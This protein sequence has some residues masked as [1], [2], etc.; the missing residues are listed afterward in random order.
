MAIF[1]AMFEFSDDASLVGTTADVWVTAGRTINWADTDLEMGGTPLWFNARVGTT[2]YAGGTSIQIKLWS[3][4]AAGGHDASS[5]VV[6]EGPIILTAAATAGAWL[7][8][9]P[10]PYNVDDLQ[11]LGVGA[12]LDGAMTAGTVDAW[13]DHGPSTSFDTQVAESNI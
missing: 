7:L 6:L 3:D 9:V 5:T 12:Y 2:A 11:Y 4:T 10:L 1:D 8:R 13:I